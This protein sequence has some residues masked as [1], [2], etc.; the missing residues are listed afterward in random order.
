[1]KISNPYSYEGDTDL[2]IRISANGEYLAINLVPHYTSKQNP[3]IEVCKLDDSAYTRHIHWYEHTRVKPL[4]DLSPDGRY[5]VT[6]HYNGNDVFEYFSNRIFLWDVHSQKNLHTYYVNPYLKTLSAEGSVNHPLF[7]G[8]RFLM[9]DFVYGGDHFVT[10]S[11]TG[12]LAIWSVSQRRMLWFVGGASL[13]SYSGA[14][15]PSMKLFVSSEHN[16]PVWNWQ[17]GPY[18]GYR[19]KFGI[20][21]F[22]RASPLGII[23]IGDKELDLGPFLSLWD[24]R[25]G[26]KIR[27]FEL[28]DYRDI[29]K[30]LCFSSD[31]RYFAGA[32]KDIVHIWDVETGK[33]LEIID[34]DDD[35]EPI[36]FTAGS[37]NL[38]IK[39]DNSLLV[40]DISKK[41]WQEKHSFDGQI[42]SVDIS[43][44]DR[45]ALATED[46]TNWNIHIVDL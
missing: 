41:G 13:A 6:A 46:E 18:V 42:G 36:G 11:E 12:E 30:S 40:W 4:F 10:I 5:L 24:C 7:F 37:S 15:S 28:T 44:T 39:S 26:A 2:K 34:Y 29:A 23:P 1:M 21:G 19:R 25:N 9:I 22:G 35:I 32:V 20:R 43:K 16:L 27:D 8:F 14:V 31:D 17:L 3:R 38:V 33:L 45:I